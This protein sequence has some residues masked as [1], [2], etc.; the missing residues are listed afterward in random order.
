MAMNKGTLALLIH[1]GTE[2]W[3]PARWK[4]RFD[5][6]C[7]DRRVWL[8]TEGGGDPKNVHYAA[9]N[10]PRFQICGLFSTSAQV[11]MP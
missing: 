5:E 7:G 9:A 6:A 3:S 4:R 2:N 1:G 8:A 10:W 11:S